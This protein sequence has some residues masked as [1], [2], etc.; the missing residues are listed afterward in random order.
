MNRWIVLAGSVTFVALLIIVSIGAWVTWPV[1]AESPSS[2]SEPAPPL[3]VGRRYGFNVSGY[4]LAGKVLEP[5]RGGWVK[6]EVQEEGKS[7]AILLRLQ[8]MPAII[9]NP[10]LE[11]IGRERVKLSSLHNRVQFRPVR[12]VLDID[13]AAVG[14]LP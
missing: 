5:P 6:V 3:Q 12:D 7:L 4:F 13:V 10:P 14:D 2:R 1:N 9:D 8:D 11:W